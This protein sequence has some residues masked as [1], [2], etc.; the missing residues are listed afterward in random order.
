MKTLAFLA[1]IAFV[2]L[3]GCTSA[4]S[5]SHDGGGSDSDSGA[6]HTHPHDA[7]VSS[8]KDAS[9]GPEVDG[10]IDGNADAG[11]TMPTVSFK[12]PKAGGKVTV[13]SPDGSTLVFDFPKSAAGL[14]IKLTP[15]SAASIGWPAGQFAQ[16]LRMEPDGT[17]FPDPIT[18]RPSSRDVIVLD[19]PSSKKKSEPEPLPVNAAGDGVLLSHFSTL[20]VV[21]AASS[22]GSGSGFRVQ[23]GSAAQAY[24]GGVAGFPTYVTFSCDASPYCFTFDL[25]CCA[26]SGATSCQL[27]DAKLAFSFKASGTSGGLYPYC[28]PALQL[29]AGADASTAVTLD[30]GVDASTAVTPDAGVDASVIDSGTPDAGSITCKGAQVACGTVCADLTSDAHNCGAC[31]KVCTFSCIESGCSQAPVTTACQQ[32]GAP[33]KSVPTSGIAPQSMGLA[34]FDG[35]GKLDIGGGTVY[36]TDVFFGAGDGS[37]GAALLPYN[38]DASAVATGD[39]DGDSHPDLMS[40]RIHLQWGTAT[41]FTAFD[42]SGYSGLTGYPGTAQFP[43]P[44][45]ESGDFNGDNRAD[46]L[47]YTSVNTG[48]TEVS[49]NSVRSGTSVTLPLTAAISAL[50]VGDFSGD[51]V[52]DAAALS[53]GNLWIFPSPL[54][55]NTAYSFVAANADRSLAAGKLD[56]DG[57]ADLVYTISG[58]GKSIGLYLSSL[59]QGPSSNPLSTLSL[60]ISA[61]AVIVGDFTHDGKN[62]IVALGSGSIVLLPGKGDGTF[63]AVQGPFAINAGFGGSGKIVTGDVTGDGTRDIVRS[64]YQQVETLVTCP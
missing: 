52:D 19:F 4:S 45:M 2:S 14:D 5:T 13:K 57:K 38:D 21:S 36:E 27:G 8:D 33:W 56:A 53:G 48:V 61:A 40:Y 42:Q 23:T 47:I 7:A 10:S 1:A 64:L 41:P 34:D 11:A 49:F 43:T 35:D 17:Q 29:D 16:V 31:N 24:C 32:G 12:V 20:A 9:S 6:S 28:A 62:D 25:M 22:C 54:A 46:A 18:V 44:P 55:A 26:K 59:D 3:A 51:T 30:A 60:P 39:F 15:V 50:A 37:F 63:G 58:S